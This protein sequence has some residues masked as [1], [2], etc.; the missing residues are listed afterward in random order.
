M[1]I[2]STIKV[3][4]VLAMISNCVSGPDVSISKIICSCQ[5][6]ELLLDNGLSRNYTHDFRA[7][8]LNI[9]VPVGF[10]LYLLTIMK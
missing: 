9:F 4:R 10:V 6:R 3:L 7:Y 1:T 2:A 8:D 5:Q